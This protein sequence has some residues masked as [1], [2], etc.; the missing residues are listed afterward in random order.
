MARPEPVPAEAGLRALHP[1]QVQVWAV[2]WAVGGLA[3]AALVLTAEIGAGVT[4]EVDLPWPTGSATGVVAVL[5]TV[6]VWRLPR[7]AFERWRYRLAESTLELY[8]GIVVRTHTAIPYFRVQHIDI[9]RSPVER[10]LGLS[11]LVVHTAAATTDAKIPGVAA[12][13]AD[14]LRDVI[15]ARSGHGDAV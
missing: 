7:L 2:W 15:L 12:A 3:T 11:Q 13:E 14:D 4:D 6:A 5:A 1:R 9:T 10:A 8:H